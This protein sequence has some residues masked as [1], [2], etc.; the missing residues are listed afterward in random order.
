MKN[1]VFWCLLSVFALVNLG[2][3]ESS[4]VERYGIT[5][6]NY[7][8]VFD[9]LVGQG[10]RL[11]RVVGHGGQEPTYD[12]VWTNDAGPQWEAR[13]SMTSANYQS[14]FD[15]LVNQGYRL[16][17]VSGYGS[18][19]SP[20]YAAIWEKRGGPA[21]EAR[22][23][24]TSSGYQRTSDDLSANGYRQTCVSRYNVGGETLYAAIWER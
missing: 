2:H 19:G 14:T 1:R 21:W 17:W 3:A 4:T 11:I 7:Q 16:T 18:G 22:H 8:R 20:L 9:E 24:L 5:S 12:S 13:H 15:N 10:Y 6:G 23:G